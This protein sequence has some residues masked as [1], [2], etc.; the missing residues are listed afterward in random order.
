VRLIED[1]PDFVATTELLHWPDWDAI[2]KSGAA[3]TESP[4]DPI[5]ADWPVLSDEETEALADAW[6]LCATD[7]SGRVVAISRLPVRPAE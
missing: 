4:L 5:P 2:H 6:E 7:I 1:E 3:V